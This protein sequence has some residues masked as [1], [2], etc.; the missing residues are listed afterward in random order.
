M[1]PYEH[2]SFVYYCLYVTLFSYI[3]VRFKLDGVKHY[4]DIEE[5]DGILPFGQSGRQSVKYKLIKEMVPG[6]P[7]L[8]PFDALTAIERCTLHQAISNTIMK[9]DSYGTNTLC[10]EIGQKLI[11]DALLLPSFATY[12]ISFAKDFE[13]K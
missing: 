10:E 2:S 12:F 8:F 9:E 6:K 11:G 13:L 4:K 5:R 7:E 1:G 3:C